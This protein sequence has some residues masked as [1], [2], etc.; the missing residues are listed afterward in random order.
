MKLCVSLVG[1]AIFFGVVSCKEKPKTVEAPVVEKSVT[2]KVIE[3]VEKAVT[4]K[5]EKSLTDDE[6]AAKLGFAKFLPKDTEMMMSVYNS[7]KAGEQLKALKLYGLFESELSKGGMAPEG[8]G[9]S[10]EGNLLEDEDAV[11]PDAAQDAAPVQGNIQEGKK[12]EGK[13][14]E[15][16]KE[17]WSPWA[18]L[19]RE[20]TVAL[21]KTGGEQTGKMLTFSRRMAYFQAKALGKAAQSYA[22]TGN[23]E[24]FNTSLQS[25]MGKGLFKNLLQDSESGVGLFDKAEMPPIY[26]AFRAKEGQLD[27]ALQLV[28]NSMAIFG[29][30]G[31]MVAPA[32]LETAGA[33]FAGYKLLGSEIAK[34]MKGGREEMDKSMGAETVDSLM[35]S[36]AKKNLIVVTGSIGDYVVMMIGGTEDSLKLTADIKESIVATDAFKF[37]DPYAD[38]QLLSIVYGEKAFWEEVIKDAGSLQSYAIGLRDGISGGGGL[39][40]TR[41]LESMLDIVVEREKALLALGSSSD[42]GMVAFV[43]D[44]LKIESFGGYDKGWIDLDAETTLSH[45]GDSGDNILFLDIPSNANYDKKMGDYLEAIVETMYAGTVKFSELKIETPELAEMKGYM[46]LFDSQFRTN[47][48]GMYSSL[49][50]L[51][52]GLGQETAVVMDL[53]GSMP[54]VPGL[55][56]KVVDEAKAPRITLISPV[57]DRS[58]IKGAWKDMDASTTSLLAKVSE[59]AGKK[60]PMQKPVSSEK[61]GMT[62]WFFPFPFFQDDFMPSVTVSDKWFA[63]STSKTKAQDLIGKAVAGGK[64][65][66]GAELRVNFNALTQYADQMLTIVESNSAQ[67]FTDES[68]LE[69]FNREKVQIKK[70]IDACRDFDS[71]SWT[72]RKEGASMH[73]S[74]HFKTK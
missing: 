54:A 39:G 37:A 6:R 58:K 34:L 51:S 40:E 52:Q 18:L 55:P 62:T 56:Q 26:I 42:L 48:V 3:T 71:M 14:E 10:I 57:T 44:G 47:V 25:E 66:N 2:E 65:G 59:M 8:D 15:G 70:V 68:K 73:S 61:D 63:M 24:D 17:E 20:V 72:I 16:K 69:D 41:D 4:P 22:K 27:Q 35:K 31:E 64:P 43:E 12:E 19:G 7:Q 29:L 33:K 60:I 13:K 46:N 36:I 1:G 50:N 32:Q 23:M 49:R 5:V 21:G 67:I 45:L 11:A 9:S 28:N 53:K 74:V 30:A 38:K